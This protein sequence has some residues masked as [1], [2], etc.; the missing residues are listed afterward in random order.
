[1]TPS[2]YMRGYIS[3]LFVYKNISDTV[4][5]I[6]DY[7]QGN[8]ITALKTTTRIQNIIPAILMENGLTNKTG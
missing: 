5:S 8:V 7:F 2:V 3:S 6:I 1:M 4:C